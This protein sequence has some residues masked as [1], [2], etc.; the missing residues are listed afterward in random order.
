MTEL[1]YGLIYFV[2]EIHDWIMT[3]NDGAA[4]MY[5]DK[6][7]HFFVM[8]VTGM[9]ILLISFALFKALGKR[10]HFLTIA[11][12]YAFTLIVVITFSVE[13][14]QWLS[15]TGQ[16]EFEDVQAGISGFLYMFVI[17]AVVRAL[18]VGLFRFVRGR[19][20]ED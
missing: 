13:I 8:G 10:G 16:M 1:L 18:I 4:Y 6:T 3:W 9:G 14:G 12:I 17:F 11:F 15:G 7:L 2:A 20:E 5:S 19:R